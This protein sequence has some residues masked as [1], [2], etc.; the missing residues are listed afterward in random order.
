MRADR[1]AYAH[2]HPHI[3]EVQDELMAEAFECWQ[4]L[5]ALT[6]HGLFQGVR[7]DMKRKAQKSEL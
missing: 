3:E 6:E 7:P 4:R 2:L 5:D 1:F